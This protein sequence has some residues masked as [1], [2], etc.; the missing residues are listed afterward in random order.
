[1]YEIGIQH[2]PIL[3]KFGN[4]AAKTPVK[5]QNNTQILAQIPVYSNLSDILW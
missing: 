5:F 1:M 2:F 4:K 3:S